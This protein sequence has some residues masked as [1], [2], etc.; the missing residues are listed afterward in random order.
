[1][2][3]GREVNVEKKSPIILIIHPTLVLYKLWGFFV[4]WCLFLFVTCLPRLSC[5]SYN[6]ASLIFWWIFVRWLISCWLWANWYEIFE[7]CVG[8]SFGAFSNRCL[9][10]V[11]IEVFFYICNKND[12]MKYARSKFIRFKLHSSKTGIKFFHFPRLSYLK[13]RHD[14]VYFI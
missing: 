11:L 9:M 10:F 2:R 6:E 1:M 8:F 13:N 4:R 7:L 5:A 12:D 3:L 14:Y